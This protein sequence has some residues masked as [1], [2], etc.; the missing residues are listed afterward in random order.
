MALKSQENKGL[1]TKE[2]NESKLMDNTEEMRKSEKRK[3]S[4]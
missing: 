4:L 2:K 1:F 3:L